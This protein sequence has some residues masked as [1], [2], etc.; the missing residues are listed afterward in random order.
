M[1]KINDKTLSWASL[2]DDNTIEQ[3][4]R[5]AELPFVSPHL[6]LMPDAHYG[7]GSTVGS[8][9]PTVGAIIPSAIG[10]DIGCG[11]IAVRTQF[12]KNNM[13]TDLSGLRKIIQRS[14]PMSVGQNNKKITPSA[15]ERINE[16][17]LKANKNYEEID[18]RWKA[19]LGSLGSGNH[20][21]E[22]TYDNEDN[23][24]AFLHSGSR[25]IGNK[26]A[27]KHIKIAQGLMK[28][29]F[30]ELPDRDLAYL[31]E[32][33]AEFDEYIQDMHW[34]QDFA[35]ASR[36]EMMDRVIKDLGYFMKEE[37]QQLERI[38][39]HHNFTQKENHMGKN[40]WLTRKGAIKADKG[41]MGLIPGSMGTASY[42]V[43]GKGNIP[44]F[45]SAPHGAGRTYSR[46]EARKRFNI[47][48]LQ[49]A[50]IGIEYREGDQF[51]DE[52]P[53][54]YKDIDKVMEDASDLV[55]VKFMFSQLLNV[56][57]D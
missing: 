57:G 24:W 13:P 23:I 27:Q 30:I 56:K 7:M 52:I 34:A 20:F 43:E 53:Q 3:A 39:C 2:I 28:K 22:I 36:D 12:K 49:K 38:N 41:L 45:K 37:V 6:A 16:L 8:V 18:K 55:E 17:E 35:L 42:V 48:D 29:Y 21:V 4:I 40:V 10:V 19:Q 54:A 46:S 15:Q 5:T 11:M 32:G 31:A 26:I 33:T 1:K 51:I 25:G 44:S 9:I 50:M 47:K 14:I